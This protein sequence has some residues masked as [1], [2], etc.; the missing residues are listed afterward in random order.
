[1]NNL[2]YALEDYIEQHSTPMDELLE[3]LYRETHLHQMNPRMMAGPT[4]GKFIQLLCQMLK[5]KRVLEIGTYTGFASIC[6]ARGLPTD[7]QLVTIEANEEYEEVIRKYLK[8]AGVAHQVELILGDAQTVIPTLA[9]SF[10]LIYID[11]DK[12]NYPLYYELVKKKTHQGSIVLADNVLWNG[13]VLDANAKDRDTQALITFNQMVQTDPTVENVILSIRDGLMM[14]RV[15]E[16]NDII[17][18]D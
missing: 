14:I 8:K 3:E 12:K 9:D 1:M 11:A 17:Y 4:Q 7:G 10:D 5:P 2:T 15:Q 16:K 13:K 6:I 18:R